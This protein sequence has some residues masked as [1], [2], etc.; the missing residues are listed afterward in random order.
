MN[1]NALG[2]APS[3]Y[4][5]SSLLVDFTTD[6][7]RQYTFNSGNRTTVYLQGWQQSSS[8]TVI[9]DVWI[10]KQAGGNQDR[11]VSIMVFL[12]WEQYQRILLKLVQ[13]QLHMVLSVLLIIL[14]KDI[15][16]I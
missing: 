7:N 4:S 8:N 1:V 16:L 9:D 5:M 15:T 10:Q 14:D 3:T 2:I 6:Y 12:L 13:K 11:S